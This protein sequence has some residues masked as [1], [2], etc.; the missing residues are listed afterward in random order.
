VWVRMSH[1]PINAASMWVLLA[2]TQDTAFVLVRRADASRVTHTA[3]AEEVQTRPHPAMYVQ[4]CN[5][6]PS[7]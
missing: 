5:L 2:Q 4:R 7:P 6:N 3:P 1:V